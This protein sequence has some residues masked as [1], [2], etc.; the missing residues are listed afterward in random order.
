[1]DAGKK[2]STS[3]YQIILYGNGITREEAFAMT[4]NERVEFSKLIEEKIKSGSSNLT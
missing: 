3:I 1:M 4:Y 2:I